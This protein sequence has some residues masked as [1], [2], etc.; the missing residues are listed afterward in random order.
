MQYFITYKYLHE[1]SE[2][3]INICEMG[4]EDAKNM[5]EVKNEYIYRNGQKSNFLIKRMFLN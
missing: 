1:L 2:S 3:K 4:R 5:C